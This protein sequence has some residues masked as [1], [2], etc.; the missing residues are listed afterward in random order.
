MNVELARKKEELRLRDAGKDTAALEAE[1]DDAEI[2]TRK[3]DM[4]QRQA[5]MVLW[6]CVLDG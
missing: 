3:A 2:Q 6:E 5:F 4:V 1:I